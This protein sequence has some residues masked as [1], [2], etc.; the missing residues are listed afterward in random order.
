MIITTHQPIFLPWP[1]FFYKAMNADYLVLLDD[2]QY[3][4]G[5]NWLNRNRLKSDSGMLWLTVPVWKKGR[6]KQIIRDVEIY[7]ELDWRLKHLRSLIHYYS[8]APYFSEIYPQIEAIYSHHHRF[9][10]DLNY[11][12]ILF[13]WKELNLKTRIIRQSDF[14]VSGKGTDLI[15]RICRYFNANQYLNFPVA[16]NFLDF[17]QFKQNQIQYIS[18]RFQP[19]IYPQLWEKFLYN[20]S[21]LD[22]VFNCREKVCDI[23]CYRTLFNFAKSDPSP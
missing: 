3:P 17:S 19:P 12:L 5:H 14:G 23:I 6:G 13:F 8:N 2:V 7:D 11:K 22:L 15:I 21:I 9:L 4:L 18:A 1:G 20:L 10:V 16:K